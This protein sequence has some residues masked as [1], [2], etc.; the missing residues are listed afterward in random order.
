M[1]TGNSVLRLVA[2][3]VGLLVAQVAVT[4]TAPAGSTGVCKDGTYTSA[5][6]KKGACRGHQ[7]VK[8]W[9]AAEADTPAK[10]SAA[11][12]PASAMPPAGAPA[13][14][15]AA[16]PAAAPAS[17]PA[18]PAKSTKTHESTASMTQAPGGGAGMVWLNG[19]TKVYH[20]PG[21]KYYGKTKEGSYMSES[22]AKAKGAHADHNHPCMK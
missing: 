12:K 3:A 22:D 5:P 11:A 19:L 10:P 2:V 13:A 6:S 21:T 14:S 17:A 1:K 8:Q 16:T 18:A 20:C 7:G 4:Q 15:K 9:L